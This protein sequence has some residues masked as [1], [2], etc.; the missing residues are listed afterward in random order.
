MKTTPRTPVP[1]ETFFAGPMPAKQDG[2][3]VTFTV[4][5]LSDAEARTKYRS[6]LRYDGDT[7]PS[8]VYDRHAR[9]S[10]LEQL[11][12]RYRA[13]LDQLRTSINPSLHVGTDQEDPPSI[14]SL[15]SEHGLQFLSVH[16]EAGGSYYGGGLT[17]IAVIPGYSFRNSEIR[18][19]AYDLDVQAHTATRVLQAG[20]PGTVTVIANWSKVWDALVDVATR[21]QAHETAQATR[22]A[23]R[24]AEEKRRRAAAAPVA[25]AL[26]GVAHTFDK[27]LDRRAYAYG[28]TVTTVGQGGAYTFTLDLGGGVS[29]VRVPQALAAKIVAAAP[30]SAQFHLTISHLSDVDAAAL[31]QMLPQQEVTHE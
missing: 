30:H 11:T 23:E 16:V 22:D 15:R 10:A 7:I 5:V 17:K 12:L 14:A 3:A 31:L 1:A 4:P 9:V 21:T 27:G 8:H 2:V 20:R 26:A 29:T 19:R 18:R 25:E 6:Y 24:K 13:L 28:T